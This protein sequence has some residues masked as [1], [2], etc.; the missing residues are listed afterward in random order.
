MI[1]E[2]LQ[3]GGTNTFVLSTE[4]ALH[5]H[6]TKLTNQITACIWRVSSNV[7][8]RVVSAGVNHQEDPSTTKTMD[9]KLNDMIRLKQPLPAPV[10]R[11]QIVATRRCAGTVVGEKVP[12]QS[13]L[14]QIPS[15]IHY[16]KTPEC[17]RLSMKTKTPSSRVKSKTPGTRTSSRTPGNQHTPGRNTFT[18]SSGCRF[19]PNRCVWSY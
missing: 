12:R 3:Q 11:W 17:G 10:E 5:Y 19:I 2:V 6:T 13:P 14:R 15:N 1:A 8:I 9:A 18:P 4:H 16:S 7:Q